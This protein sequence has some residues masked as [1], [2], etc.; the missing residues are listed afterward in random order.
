MDVLFWFV[1]IVFGGGTLIFLGMAIFAFRKA[2]KR[3]K[4][5]VYVEGVIKDISRSSYRNRSSFS[6]S[7][8]YIVDEQPY[9]TNILLNDRELALCTIGSPF[10]LVCQKDRPENAARASSSKFSASLNNLFLAALCFGAL[11]YLF[12]DMG[13]L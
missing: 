8:Q 3:M 5:P 10:S 4:N 9:T 6:A 13:Y 7:I 2:Q 11:V 12:Y 1:L